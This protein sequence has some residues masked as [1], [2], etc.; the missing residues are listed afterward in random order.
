MSLGFGFGDF[1]AVIQLANGVR[2]IFISAPEQFKNISDEVRSLSIVLQDVELIIAEQEPDLSEKA[3]LEIIANGCRN[4]LEDL[5][6]TLSKYYELRTEPKGF[7][8]G[9]KRAWKRL[10]WEPDDITEIRSRITSNITL[11]N[12]FSGRSTRVRVV[13][14]LQYQEDRLQHAVLDWL[15]PI[16]YAP[17]HNTFSSQRLVG[18]G[19]WFLNSEE[20]KIWM[21][22]EKQTLFCPGILGAGKTMIASAVVDEVINQFANDNTIGIAYIYCGSQQRDEP[23]VEDFLASLLKQFAEGRPSLPD[24]VKSLYDKHKD[25]R[26]RPSF[27]DMSA[28]LHLVAAEYSRLVIVID[29]LDEFPAAGGHRVRLISQLFSLQSKCK[30]QIFATSRFIKEITTKFSQTDTKVIYASNEDV[31]LYL[32]AHMGQLPSFVQRNQ[33]LQDMIKERISVAVGGMFLLARVYLDSL[34]DKL[35]VSAV[36]KALEEFPKQHQRPSDDQSS[37]TREAST[38]LNGAY[39]QAI[40]RIKNQRPGFLD[41]AKRVMAWLTYARRP[42]TAT[43]LQHAL[44]VEEGASEFDNDISSRLDENNLPQI[45]DMVSVCAG[46]V[47]V[48]DESGRIRLLH[49]TAQKYLRR[50]GKTWFPDAE[51]EITRTCVTY[52][53]FSAFESG[54][55]S[56][57]DE[58]ENRLRINPFYDYAARNWG[59]HARTAF[60]RGASLDGIIV[61]LLEN[62]VKISSSVQAMMVFQRYSLFSQHI[63]TNMTGVHVAAYFGLLTPIKALHKNGADLESR[64]SYG[65]TPLSWA[66]QR[67]NVNIV[68]WLLENGADPNSKAT[69]TFMHGCTPLWFAAQNGHKS[70]VEV[71]LANKEIESD[72]KIVEGQTP[73]SRASRNGH[74]SVVKLFL[75][76]GANVNS[77]DDNCRTP[78]S[79]AAKNGHEAVV[80]TLLGASQVDV[81]A[82]DDAGETA[83]GYAKK[84]GHVGIVQLLE[85]NSRDGGRVDTN[86][87]DRHD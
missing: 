46:L 15:T 4:V 25:K 35:A 10:K 81:N 7:G 6:N 77:I 55:C 9:I 63:P 44:A 71:L 1:L 83:L 24:S 36:Q 30:A 74:E 76:N 73:L 21:K 54:L 86:S 43:E 62:D 38:L 26:T 16:D 58:F 51:T 27:D 5:E 13:K 80:R 41:L 28:T 78:L 85:D 34:E 37:A 49:Y 14:L 75:D 42:L 50:V 39:D 40:Q 57:D 65:R 72:S 22:A 3:D 52:L 87:Q 79:L 82:K 20:F 59:H 19:Q 17:Q 18:S 66:A 11:L 70:V 47:D 8:R 45:E 48:D 53:L 31:H 33:R 12:A 64:D 23:K 2:R 68:E 69:A 67:D 84:N 56:T 29:A 60:D 32:N 61:E